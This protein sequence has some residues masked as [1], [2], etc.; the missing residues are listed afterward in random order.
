MVLATHSDMGYLNESNA[1][2][3]VR[4]HHYLSE[5]IPLTHNNGAILNVAEII[6]AIM[7]SASKAELGALN[8][9]ACEVVEERQILKKM[10]HP[11][12]STP[13]QTDNSKVE[14]IINS[15]VQPKCTKA[16]DMRF[17]WLQNCG[18]N[19]QQ[20][21]FFWRPVLFN[22]ADYWTKHHPPAHH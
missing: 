19:Q 8:I 22:Y 4:G 11:Q 1:R 2:S 6:K 21:R 17:H 5:N 10:G 12:P 20:F 14:G 18:E 7:S 15:K 16:M 9:N 13:I 3:M